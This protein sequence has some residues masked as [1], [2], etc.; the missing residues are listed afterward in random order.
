MLLTLGIVYASITL[1]LLKRNIGSFLSIYFSPMLLTLGIV[2]ANITPLL[3]K[4][5]IGSY[6][7]IYFSPMLLTLG[8]VYANITPLL[9]KRNIG[10]YSMLL[11]F[12]SPVFVVN[13]QHSLCNSIY[14][15]INVI[16]LFSPIQYFLSV[17]NRMRRLLNSIP[18]R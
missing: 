11:Q 13:T 17:L 15:T 18:S 8:I 16:R 6:L 5:N 4:R 14:I 7:S 3:L 10:S 1:L 2:Y 12:D 9:L